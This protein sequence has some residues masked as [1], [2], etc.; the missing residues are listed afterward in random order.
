M[1][2][3][4]QQRREALKNRLVG[5]FNQ[6]APKVMKVDDLV[7]NF[8]RED[9]K[10]FRW[11][12]KPKEMVLEHMIRNMMGK[13]DVPAERGVYTAVENGH[14]V[15][16]VSSDFLRRH[17]INT[18]TSGRA[19]NYLDDIEKAGLAAVDAVRDSPD[20]SAR[21][22]SGEIKPKTAPPKPPKH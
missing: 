12:Q 10:Y 18:I 2:D 17:M 19:D 14:T 1:G 3:N 7:N 5:A 13:R 15:N 22:K 21:V 20:Q 9:D 8:E 16:Y 11:Y 6:V 4:I